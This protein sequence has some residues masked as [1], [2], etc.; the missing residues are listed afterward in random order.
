M[1]QKFILI[2][3][4]ALTLT[5]I[6]QYFFAPKNTNQVDTKTDITMSIKDDTLTIPNLPHIEIT[7]HGTG[8]TLLPCEM[9]SISVDSLV[10]QDINT[11]FPAFCTPVNIESGKAN[12]LP[13]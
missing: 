3:L 1:N 12:T 6:F 5:L 2:A 4:Y 9:V 8:W 10:I 7:N 11:A 13:L